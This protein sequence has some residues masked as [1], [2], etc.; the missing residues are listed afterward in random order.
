MPV[1]SSPL[2]LIAADRREARESGDPWAALCCLGTVDAQGD[3]QMR[4]LVL[5]DVDDQLALFFSGTSPKWRELNARDRLTLMLYLPSVQVQYRLRANFSELP[6]AL[7]RSSWLLR[8]EVPKKLDWLY[9]E[10]PQSSAIERVLL[11]ERL[12]EHHP[13]PT[14]APATAKGIFIEPFEIERLQ[15]STGVHQRERYTLIDD[16]WQ[17]QHITP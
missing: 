9:Q 14:A 10:F 3:A 5:R 17:R 6:D 11:E 4:T 13:T 15:L 16:T 1:E 2:N 8:P 12:A 7:I